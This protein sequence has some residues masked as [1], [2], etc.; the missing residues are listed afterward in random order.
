MGK[1]Y[2]GQAFKSDPEKIIFDNFA[3]GETYV[4][5]VKMTN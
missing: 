4:Q 3:I 1:A 5:K 2:E